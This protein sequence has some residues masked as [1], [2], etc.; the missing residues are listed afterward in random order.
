[1]WMYLIIS[2]C[3]KEKQIQLVIT[4]TTVVNF[5]LQFYLFTSTKEVALT[6]F[7][8]PVIPSTNI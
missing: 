3:Q 6:G 4:N 7:P 1:M 2:T 5:N 8:S